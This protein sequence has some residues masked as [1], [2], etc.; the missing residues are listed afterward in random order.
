[1]LAR[2]SRGSASVSELAR[3]LSMSLPAV[4]QH[5]RAL[6]DSGLVRSEKRGRV[7]T[8]RLEPGVLSQA[9]QWLTER[10]NEW[11]AHADRLEQYLETLKKEEE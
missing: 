2:L 9:E 3:P 4:L 7:R 10:R 8:V 11:E 1:M 6:E 5:L